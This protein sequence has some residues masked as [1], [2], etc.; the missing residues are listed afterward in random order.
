V[1]IRQGITASLGLL[2]ARDRRYLALVVAVQAALALLDLAGVLF[3][4]FVAALSTGVV[5][6]TTPS[7]VPT[8]LQL[9]GLGGVDELRL[10]LYLAIAAGLILVLKSGLSFTVSRQVFLFLARRQAQVSG[11][12]SSRLLARPLLYVQG[13]SSQQTSYAL[14]VGVNA[15]TIGVLGSA[16]V[17]ASEL[18]LLLVLGVGL[19]AIDLAISLFTIAFFAVVAAAVHRSLAGWA[20]RLGGSAA[21]AEVASIESV[22]VALRT[23]RESS[24]GGRRPLFVQRFRTLRTTAARVQADMQVVNLVPKYILEAAI[25]IGG[26]LLV[27]SQ[28]ATRDVVAAVGVIAVFLT[29]ASRI[30]PSVLRL[31]AALLNIKASTGLA[32]PT[33]AIASELK[34]STETAGDDEL[35]AR[36]TEQL[37]EHCIRHGYEDFE[38]TVKITKV[39]FSFPAGADAQIRG[40]TLD[41]PAGTSLALVGP[42]GAGKTTIAD[43]ALGLFVPD[44]GEVLISGHEPTHAIAMWPGAI[45]YVPQEVPVISGTIRDNVALG[46]PPHLTHDERVWAAL[47]QA[48]LAD[49]L[50]EQR[51][52]LDTVVGEH[53]VRLSGG[54]RQR[55]GMA[56][57]LYT[58]PRLLVLD[59]ATSALDS[60][61]EKAISD[62]LHS[63]HG[64]VTL[65]VIAHR[66]ATIRTADQIAYIE[67]GRVLA[68]GTFDFVRES[69]PEFHR[70]AAILGL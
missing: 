22:Q 31:Q 4:G 43:L 7:I 13:R 8:T 61:T 60:V 67:D 52:G 9:V 23:F 53:G 45:A 36:T 46:L 58:R 32:E 37:M 42:T 47:R 55:L 2:R 18:S 56:R 11:D 30:M 33:Y 69:V 63:L 57:A 24:V 68:V 14:T 10:A 65:I 1:G 27:L 49:F 5:T 28:V 29:A 51:D 21:A 35:R 64:T 34:G 20:G 41:V 15:A 40:V 6:G 38:P 16:V 25:V 19:A 59:E 17:L 12:L 48:H 70:Q 66:L 50:R 44:S 3:L 54:Q 26:G 62:T 39:G